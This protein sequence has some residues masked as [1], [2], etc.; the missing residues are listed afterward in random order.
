MVLTTNLVGYWKLDANS[1]DSLGTNN[2]TD[3][4]TSYATNGKISKCATFTGTGYIN[5]TSPTNLPLGNGSYTVAFWFKTSSAAGSPICVSL[6]TTGAKTQLAIGIAVTSGKLS[7]SW[8]GADIT[9]NTANLADGTWHFV[10]S[11]WDGTTRL[12]YLDNTALASDTPSAANLNITYGK[13]RFGSATD[14]SERL[15]GSVD[16]IGIWTRA[17]TSAEAST[18]YNSNNGLTYPFVT[19]PNFKINVG[20]AWKT[21]SKVQINVGDAWKDVTTAKINVGDAW[22]NI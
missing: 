18:L 11:T 3:T 14:N 22:K 17:L 2:G 7:V 10:V 21:V 15:N 9:Y 13:M 4:N 1:N 16:E 19:T 8:Y 6:G 5:K 12:T 20:D